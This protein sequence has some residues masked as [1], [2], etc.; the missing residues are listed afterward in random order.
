MTARLSNNKLFLLLAV[1]ALSLLGWSIAMGAMGGGSEAP[2]G[3]TGGFG[4]F[5]VKGYVSYAVHDADGNLIAESLNPN[6]ITDDG[7]AAL[8]GF[9]TT[10]F[11][12][13]AI[14]RGASTAATGFDSSAETVSV[15]SDW[16]GTDFTVQAQFTR[17]AEGGG[18]D[19]VIERILFGDGITGTNAFSDAGVFAYQ[20]EPSDGAWDVSGEGS[21]IT[22]NWTIAIS[23]DG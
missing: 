6:T 1:A 19:G 16:D 22:F 7:L 11:D 3:G 23:D 5:S 8:A 21:T 10:T 15:D 17:N 9:A 2:A 13:I 18:D 4:N 20:E 12:T 14:Q